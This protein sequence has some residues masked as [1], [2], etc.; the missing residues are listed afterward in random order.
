VKPTHSFVALG[1]A[2][3]IAHLVLSGFNLHELPEPDAVGIAAFAIETCKLHDTACG[4]RTQIGTIWVDQGERRHY[5]AG[6]DMSAVL[7][8]AAQKARM[9]LHAQ[10][11]GTVASI[12]KRELKK[13]KPTVG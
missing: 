7:E 6:A 10:T 11:R 12:M 1:C 3:N 9:K 4:G 13:I 5:L 8:T 2:A